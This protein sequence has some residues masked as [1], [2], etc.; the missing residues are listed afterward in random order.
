MDQDRQFASQEGLEA[1]KHFCSE[2]Y[3]TVE[4]NTTASV[5]GLLGLLLMRISTLALSD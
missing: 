1:L 2:I 3:N 4:T 5:S